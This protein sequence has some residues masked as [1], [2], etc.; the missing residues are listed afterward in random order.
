MKRCTRFLLI[1]ALSTIL[2]AAANVYSGITIW[3]A[4]SRDIWGCGRI[5]FLA[6]LGATSLA[7]VWVQAVTGLGDSLKSRSNECELGATPI[8]AEA[9]G[10]VDV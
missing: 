4:W 7:N 2:N 10:Q 6:A 3:K 8:P 5:V 9:R 1:A